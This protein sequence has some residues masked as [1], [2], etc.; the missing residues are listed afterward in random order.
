MNQHI[1]Q[2]DNN[3]KSFVPKNRLMLTV[4][5]ISTVVVVFCLSAVLSS[6]FF[7]CEKPSGLTVQINM[8]TKRKVFKQGE[9]FVING[10]GY[11]EQQGALARDALIWISDL[12]GQVGMGSHL[13]IKNLSDGIHK[14]TLTGVNKNGIQEIDSISLEIEYSDLQDQHPDEPEP[15]KHGNYVDNADGTIDD[16]STMLSWQKQGDTSR[17]SWKQACDYCENMALNDFDDWRAPTLE[18]L[19]NI[20][21]ISPDHTS[22]LAEPFKF[23]PGYYWTTTKSD[24]KGKK[25]NKNYFWTVK[26]FETD[27][28][29]LSGKALPGKIKMPLY[30]VCVRN[31]Q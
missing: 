27:S 16:S 1:D 3:R 26:F 9:N 25:G 15:V 19:K 4:I 6:M 2:K 21:N 10:Y 17:R 23:T 28:G 20:S 13:N 18:E 29:K 5:T 8:E 14:I 24:Y 11:D 22:G 7:G 12:D 30:V 31:I